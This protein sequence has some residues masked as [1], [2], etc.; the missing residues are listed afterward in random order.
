MQPFAD[1][2]A[3]GRE[4]AIRL[5]PYRQDPELLVLGLPR[6]GMPVAFEIARHLDAPLDVMTV[7]KIGAPGQPELAIGAIASGGVAVVNEKLRASFEDTAAI[8]RT[9][10][11]ER[12]ELE[13]REKTYRRGLEPL[14]A[15][16]RTVILVDD[17]A[18][19]GATM[20]AAVL[21]MRKLGAQKIVIALPVAS[22][23]AHRLLCE[24]ADEVIC[25]GVPKE[26]Y[27]VGQWYAGFTQTTD[28]YVIDLLARARHRSLQ[29][30]D[31]RE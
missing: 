15:A 3:A 2:A 21:A 12:I 17:G 14:R 11:A 24:A 1:R 27:A 18:A 9:E 25:L 16:G 30:R 31:T 5:E 20:Y 26:F 6:G 8:E 22:R 29:G 19:T 7:R 13:R 23:E 4:L 28:A 10:A